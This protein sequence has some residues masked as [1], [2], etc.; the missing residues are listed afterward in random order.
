MFGGGG[1]MD[2]PLMPSH[3]DKAAESFGRLMEALG[4]GISKVM[5]KITKSVD[6]SVDN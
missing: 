6:K 3:I 1:G 5:H 4:R 2:G